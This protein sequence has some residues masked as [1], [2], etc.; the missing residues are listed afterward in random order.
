ME[1]RIV[2]KFEGRPFEKA[3][4]FLAEEYRFDARELP[5]IK[6]FSSRKKKK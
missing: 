5:A 6:S 2:H 3:V 4:H 1:F